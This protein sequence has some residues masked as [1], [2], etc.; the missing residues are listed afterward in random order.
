MQT[1]S[2][3]STRQLKRRACTPT[4]FAPE[5]D[6]EEEEIVFTRRRRRRRVAVDTDEDWEPVEEEEEEEE[7]TENEE[8]SGWQPVE[9]EE[10]EIRRSSQ[11]SGYIIRVQGALSEK[12]RRGTPI[13]ASVTVLAQ[14]WAVIP[15]FR[16]ANIGGRARHECML[17]GKTGIR[18][19]FRIVNKYERDPELTIEPIGSECVQ[20]MGKW[21]A[22]TWIMDDTLSKEYITE[23]VARVKAKGKK[24][25]DILKG[26][27]S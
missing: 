18:Y 19:L 20:M 15:S 26:I 25:D 23:F 5:D 12:R 7:E 11:S 21:G 24:V 9:E 16:N 6:E 4:I 27:P 8:D 14:E 13:D 2:G 17:C 3:R 1:R 10:E 22:S